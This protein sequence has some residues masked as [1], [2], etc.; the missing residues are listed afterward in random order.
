MRKAIIFPLL[1]FAISAPFI[2]C[3]G[4]SNNGLGQDDRNVSGSWTGALTRVSDTCT[5]STAAQTLNFSD[6]VNQN[7][8][9]VTLTDENGMSYL[10]NLVGND[11]FSVDAVGFGAIEGFQ[12]SVS[13]ANRLRY[14]DINEDS[15]LTAAV[16][17]TVTCTGGASCEINYTGTA[18]RGTSSTADTPIGPIAGGCT[19]INPDTASGSYSGD[20]KCGLSEAKYSLN[21]STVLLEPFGSNGTTSFAISS[22]NSSSATSNNTDLTIKGEAGYSCSMVCSPPLTFTV[23][24]FK[25]GGATCAEKF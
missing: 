7:G 11:G 9:A 21:G 3:G 8:E 6:T 4:G 13:P 24:C 22:T 5:G 18:S 16:E 15:D 23:S 2:G 12:C 17:M 20:G 1:V 19:A 25:E 14:S 10:G